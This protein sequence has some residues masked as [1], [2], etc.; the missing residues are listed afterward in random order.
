M[1]SKLILLIISNSNLNPPL[2][3]PPYDYLFP[4]FDYPYYIYEA[5]ILLLPTPTPAMMDPPRLDHH[6]SRE[7]SRPSSIGGDNSAGRW[8]DMPRGEM[9]VLPPRNT[10]GSRSNLEETKGPAVRTAPVLKNEQ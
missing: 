7:G 8:E 9:P 10:S 6:R 2:P 5:R 4:G 1:G 3:R